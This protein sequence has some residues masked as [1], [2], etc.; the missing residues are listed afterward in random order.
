[1]IV[2]DF[3]M[4]FMFTVNLHEFTD[5]TVKG[6]FY[7]KDLYDGRKADAWLDV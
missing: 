3:P 4:A 5:N 6:W 7:P 2:K 1:M